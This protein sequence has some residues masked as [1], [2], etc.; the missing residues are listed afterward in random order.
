M[1]YVQLAEQFI[2]EYEDTL[3]QELPRAVAVR[4]FAAWLDRLAAG[5]EQADS[6]Q[7]AGIPSTLYPTSS[8]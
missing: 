3:Y 6:K 4:E 8:L 7:G 2:S 5:S 1:D